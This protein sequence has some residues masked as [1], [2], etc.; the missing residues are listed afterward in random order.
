MTKT[1]SRLIAFGALFLTLLAPPTAAEPEQES[2]ESKPG[3]EPMSPDNPHYASGYL[4]IGEDFYEGRSSKAELDARVAEMHRNRSARRKDHA[5]GLKDQWG[6]HVLNRPG[7]R[8]ELRTHARREAFLY[9]ALFLAHTDP[10]VKARAA[11]VA[12]IDGILD[13]ELQRHEDVMQGFKAALAG[14]P[15][16]S[17]SPSA[18]GK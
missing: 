11:L 12:R 2:T 1:R 7:V 8:E 10:S 15:S 18:G 3:S 14:A 6:G 5:D 9:R 4:S 13:K 17:P 16:P